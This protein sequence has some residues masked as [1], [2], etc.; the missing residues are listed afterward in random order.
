MFSKNPSN[1][2]DK[3]LITNNSFDF[4]QKYPLNYYLLTFASQYYI[5][6]QIVQK[7][8]PANVN[9]DDNNI[10]STI[11]FSEK[12]IQIFINHC[13]HKDYHVSR[14]NAI[15][16]YYLAKKYEIKSLIKEINEYFSN[17]S[18][19]IIIQFLLKIQN[20]QN[21][22]FENEITT[23]S[24]NLIDYIDDELMLLIPIPF[25]YQI[26]EKYIALHSNKLISNPSIIELFFKFLDKYGRKASILF[27]FVSFRNDRLIYLNRLIS[28][29]SA[30]FDF[31]FINPSLL[32]ELIQNEEEIK[33]QEKQKD[34]KLM[35]FF[36]VELNKK[37]N[38][39]NGFKNLL[40]M[41]FIFFSLLIILLMMNSKTKI[42]NIEK[43]LAGLNQKLEKQSKRI[44]RD[45]GIQ[46]K[47]ITAFN[48][49]NNANCFKMKN[50][51]INEICI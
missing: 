43:E 51:M 25:I 3:F 28:D 8:D 7:T 48:R 30:I 16:L 39:I 40:L 44:D 9:K 42:K 29:Y 32:K 20:S 1:S 27:S 22:D 33:C 23:L 49:I 35:E 5:N 6:N 41:L 18:N 47:I 17:Y 36:K 19:D 46:N 26:I 10:N 2:N 11:N 15:P 45:N 50:K 21:S 31:N 37:N 24:N 13:N 34:A 38:E 4:D 14:E 12:S